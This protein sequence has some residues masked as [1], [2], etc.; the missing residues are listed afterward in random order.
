MSYITTALSN[1][2]QQGLTA[3]QVVVMKGDAIKDLCGVKR[4]E[5]SPKDFFYESIRQNVFREF[6]E[7]ESLVA[8]TELKITLEAA[9]KDSGCTV[10]VNDK[11]GEVV[12]K[13]AKQ[14]ISE[15]ID[16]ISTKEITSG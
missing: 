8:T 11:T 5:T 10:E 4:G 3:A 16:T 7:A 6:D 1:A 12:V 14:V 13:T 9:M 2:S 15:T